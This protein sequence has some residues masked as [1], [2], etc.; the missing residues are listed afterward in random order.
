MRD[1][2]QVGEEM[3]EAATAG[4]EHGDLPSAER[5]GGVERE[6]EVGGV[7]VDRVPVDPGAAGDR[8][9]DLR[10][11][12]AVEIADHEVDAQPQRERVG[13]TGVGRDDERCRREL[14][15]D[16]EGSVASGDHEC[17]HAASRGSART[18]RHR[19]GLPA[20]A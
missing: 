10:G 18:R 3:I 20:P 4:A 13:D 12:G 19:I 14:G 9:L 11:L 2:E 1:Q 7:L 8:T 15:L 5:A 16:R 6:L 17:T